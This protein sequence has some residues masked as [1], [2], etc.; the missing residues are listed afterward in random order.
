MAD[1][2]TIYDALEGNYEQELRTTLRYTKENF[3]ERGKVLLMRATVFSFV[4][5]S[6]P[7]SEFTGSTW[8]VAEIEA[9]LPL[10]IVDRDG[11]LRRYRKVPTHG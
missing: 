9:A 11:K 4:R 6:S 8:T 1:A 10:F 2:P 3:G 5:A 7:A